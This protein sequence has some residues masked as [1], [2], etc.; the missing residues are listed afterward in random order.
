MSLP[1][2]GKN[3]STVGKI[4]EKAGGLLNNQKI[5]DK[6]HQKREQAGLNDNTGAYGSGNA[7]SYGSGNTNTYGSGNN[8]NNDY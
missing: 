8:N 3:D 2:S 7:D 6:G 1:D 4:M 5:A